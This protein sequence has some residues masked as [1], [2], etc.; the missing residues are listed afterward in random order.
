M[1]RRCIWVHQ[2]MMCLL[3]LLLLL[4]LFLL[5]LSSGAYCRLFGRHLDT[6]EAVPYNDNHWRNVVAVLGLSKDQVGSNSSTGP[7]PLQQACASIGFHPSL[8]LWICMLAVGAVLSQPPLPLS[9]MLPNL[10]RLSYTAAFSLAAHL[11]FHPADIPAFVTLPPTPPPTP[12]GDA[13]PGMC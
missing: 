13:Q 5:L 12:A 2:L 3:L 1:F 11:S 9:P 10:S 4:L 6:G 7:A 8:R